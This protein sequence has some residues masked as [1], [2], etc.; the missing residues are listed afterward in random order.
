VLTFKGIMK[1]EIVHSISFV[2]KLES[3]LR[4]R[5]GW[6]VN[7]PVESPLL[8]DFYLCPIRFLCFFRLP[9]PTSFKT[10]K[11]VNTYP[12]SE[13]NFKFGRK[14]V[15]FLRKE[16]RCNRN[17][18]S[19]VATLQEESHSERIYISFYLFRINSKIQR[20]TG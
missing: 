6:I 4:N 12:C 14:Y 17:L 13:Q 19:F 9:H 5:V 3:Y 16:D 18:F 20:H 10:P 11:I 7:A 15:V 1:T 8:R 2:L